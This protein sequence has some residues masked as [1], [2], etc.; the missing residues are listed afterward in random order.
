MNRK[1]LYV[2]IAAALFALFGCISCDRLY[3]AAMEKVGIHKRDIM[4]DRVKEARETQD[5]TKKQFVTAMEQF[6]SVVSFQ[7]G[8]LEKEYNKL[9]STFKK[10]ESK[11]VE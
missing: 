6:K 11:A 4:V 1:N 5:E 8:N 7:G 3:Y 2:V 10:S 9:N